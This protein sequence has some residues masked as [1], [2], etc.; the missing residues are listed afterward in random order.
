MPFFQS[1]NLNSN[2]RMTVMPDPYDI[3]MFQTPIIQLV[4]PPW[5]EGFYILV[6]GANPNIKLGTL[7]YSFTYEF[8]PTSSYYKI[9]YARKP[10]GGAATLT[11]LDNLYSACPYLQSASFP[12]ARKIAMYIA[13][14]PSSDHDTLLA[15]TINHISGLDMPRSITQGFSMG[16]RTNRSTSQIGDDNNSLARISDFN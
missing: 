9:C 14:H 13:N 12:C 5:T 2:L 1:N 7:T 6:T 3:E 10:E 16:P 15:D 4:Q 11:F 8:V